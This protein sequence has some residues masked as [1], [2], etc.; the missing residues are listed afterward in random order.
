MIANTMRVR[1]HT[2]TQI[3]VVTLQRRLR[4]WNMLELARSRLAVL[5]RQPNAIT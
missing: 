3:R 4:G 1:E 5:L 2:R